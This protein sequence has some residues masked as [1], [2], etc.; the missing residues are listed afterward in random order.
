[1]TRLVIAGLSAVALLVMTGCGSDNTTTFV[2]ESPTPT[3]SGSPTG[4]PSASPSPA[5]SSLPTTAATPIEGGL[6]IIIDSPDAGTAISSPVQ[7]TGTASVDNG[8]VVATVLD[9]A[10]NELGRATTLASAAKP[11]FGH[12]EVSVSFTGMAGKKGQIKAFGV[13][14]RDGKTPTNFYFITVTFA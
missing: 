1:M 8:T 14:P 4:S 11:E 3:A 2:I 5:S 7:V 12:Y 13:S 6:K 9:A 10:G